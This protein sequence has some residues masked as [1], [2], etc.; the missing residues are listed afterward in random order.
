MGEDKVWQE[1]REILEGKG[2]ADEQDGAGSPPFK[3]AKPVHCVRASELPVPDDDDWICDGILEVGEVTVL[4]GR[5]Q[6]G[7]STLARFLAACV[8][9]G[10]PFLGRKTKRGPVLLANAEEARG[11]VR[12]CFVRLGVAE[13]QD[14]YMVG[15]PLPPGMPSLTP[16]SLFATAKDAGARLVVVDSL[17]SLFP[18][19]PTATYELSV[20]LMAYLQ[21]LARWAGSS[22]LV[23]VH[24]EEEDWP[25]DPNGPPYSPNGFTG[26]MG[27]SAFNM[28]MTRDDSGAWIECQGREGMR[29][30][31]TLLKFDEATQ[32]FDPA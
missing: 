16:A 31:K 14:L 24:G 3:G 19:E 1:I 13:H 2:E 7:K 30:P 9:E 21:E 6:V 15:L 25:E 23:I 26:L 18:G 32:R 20:D 4:A 29:L 27:A 28:E 10:R 22:A 17:A 12:E 11:W 8:L 5:A